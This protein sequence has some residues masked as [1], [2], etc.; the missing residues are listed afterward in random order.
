MG[1]GRIEG[2]PEGKK[3]ESV[4]A[5]KSTANSTSA[6]GVRPEGVNRRWWRHTN[7]EY[8]LAPEWREWALEKLGVGPQQ[9]KVDLFAT[10][11]KAARSLFVTRTMDAFSF[12]WHELVE[13]EDEVLWANPPFQS[14]EKVVAKLWQEPC[15][16]ALCCPEWQAHAWWRPLHE[17]VVDKIYLPE[18]QG[19]YYGVIKK[20]ILPPPE[21][22]S[23]VCIVDSRKVRAPYPINKV[24]RWLNERNQGKG[25]Q[26]L[27]EAV[28]ALS[29]RGG[30]GPG[31]PGGTARPPG[32]EAPETPPEEQ[33]EGGEG[34]PPCAK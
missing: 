34:T 6:S 13:S 30:V 18:A 17:L 4:L 14:M 32:V 33:E 24:Q 26:A 15:R 8:T 22:R 27:K 3:D 9:V 10:P 5:I 12:N 19:L 2:D 16:L 25:L 1:G 28:R 7:G 29:G 11:E 23:F 31:D 20:D 21:W